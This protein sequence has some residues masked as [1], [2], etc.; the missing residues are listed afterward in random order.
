M[1]MIKTIFDVVKQRRLKPQDGSYTSYL[2]KEGIDK[3]LKKLGE[4]ATETVIAA[5][6]PVP[7]RLIQEMADLYYHTIVLMEAYGITPDQVNNELEKRHKS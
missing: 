1:H 2:Q 6:N 7:V 5:K 4:E 3:I